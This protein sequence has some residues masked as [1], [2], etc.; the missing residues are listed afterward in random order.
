LG[1]ACIIIIGIIYMVGRGSSPGVIRAEDVLVGA[2]SGANPGVSSYNAYEAG[3]QTVQADA[4]AFEPGAVEAVNIVVHI[5]GAVNAPGVFELPDGSRINDVLI[6][7]GGE[8]EYADLSRINLAAFARDAMQII[9]PVLGEEIDE[10]FIF[11]EDNAPA[12]GGISP[13]AVQGS[14]LININTATA[15]ELQAL[16]G[17]GP[18]LS[19]NIID[20]RETHGAFAS[21]GELINVARI[22]PATLERI[23]ELVTVG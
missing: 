2:N 14:G 10:V 7:A 22:G 16:P 3:M 5:I 17:I 23:R 20:F 6:L 1:G 8:T 15:A 4:P 11:S 13:A 9:V 18:V 19:Q 21:V 12:A